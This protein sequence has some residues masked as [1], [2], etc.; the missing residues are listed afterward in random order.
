MEQGE[1][2]IEWFQMLVSSAE[3]YMGRQGTLSLK[4]LD[5]S[6]QEGQY[7]LEDVTAFIQVSGAQEGG[8]LFTVD[9]KLSLLFAK[10]YMSEEITDEEADRYA[11]EV[12]AEMAN[13]ISG[14]ALTDRE[15]HNILLGNPL[16]ILTKK[17]EIH[18]KCRRSYLQAYGSLDGSFRLIYI[19]MEH[20]A[21]LASILA[22][23]L[24]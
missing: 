4:R 8:F 1:K 22:V 6:E 5:L 23:R 15:L 10:L 3:N 20:R 21:E 2:E 16:M 19:P 17:A 11:V 12:V 9:K 14:N 13:V 18:A 24:D 7:K